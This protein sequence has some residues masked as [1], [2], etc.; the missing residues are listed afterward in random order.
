MKMDKVKEILDLIAE[1]Q[2]D[3]TVPKNIKQK[4]SEMAEELKNC[5][6]EELTL[7]VNRILSTLEELSNDTNI[8]TF[9]RTQ[10]WNL[11]S[12]LEAIC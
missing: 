2:E 4:V 5:P 9:V 12:L 7:K 8:P 11:T 10:I 6:E 1:M 3:S